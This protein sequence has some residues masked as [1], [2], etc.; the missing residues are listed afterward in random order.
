[1]KKIVLYFF[2][3]LTVLLLSENIYAGPV[4]T[5]SITGAV[6]QPLDLTIEYLKT[7]RSIRVQLN[8]IT[9]KGEFK[10]VFHYQGVP[11]KNL[12]ELSLIDKGKTDFSKSIDL[13]I[14]I[15]NRAGKQVVLSWGEVF[16]KNPGQVILAFF[17]EPVIPHKA[18]KNCHDPDVYQP[19]L[20]QFERNVGFPKLVVS[21]DS[22]SDRSMEEITEI[23]VVDMKPEIRVKKSEK[24]YSPEFTIKD[25][26]GRVK[27]VV[28]KKISDYPLSEITVKVVGEGKGYHGIKRF[29]GVPLIK[30]FENA[31]IKADID[32][33]ILISA[34]DGYRSLL[35][36]G[37]IFLSPYGGRIIIADKANG[38]S[39]KR[40]GKFCL[41]LPDDLMADRWVKA[42]KKIEIISFKK[43]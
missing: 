24:L 15:K 16:Y 23:R 9:K 10:G 41:I 22:Y 25:I 26:P 4:R 5:V 6:R 34:P 31:K 32:T 43:Q 27:P 38:Q 35:S 20:S 19:W 7:C 2:W 42:V 33:V 30:L 11:L 39:L 13:A 8:E 3:G 21:S 1:M 28:I 40:G 29:Q 36:S 12:L 17:S 14:L 37:E 18:C